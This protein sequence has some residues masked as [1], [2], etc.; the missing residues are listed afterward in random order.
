MDGG[1]I[2]PLWR[3]WRAEGYHKLDMRDESVR[4]LKALNEE[5]PEIDLAHPFWFEIHLADEN[6]E[7]LHPVAGQLALRRL[8]DSRSVAFEAICAYVRFGVWEATGAILRAIRRFPKLAQ[9]RILLHCFHRNAG[10]AE[11]AAHWLREAN[12][13]DPDLEA[14]V[15]PPQSEG[16][17]LASVLGRWWENPPAPERPVFSPLL[18]DFLFVSNLRPLS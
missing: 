11:N 14:P 12:R 8:G 15:L 17:R 3:L 1:N 6:W 2:N 5:V 18:S 7:A 9:F 10:H 16:D 13:L 4:E